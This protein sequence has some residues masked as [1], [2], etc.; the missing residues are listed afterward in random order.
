MTVHVTEIATW[1]EKWSCSPERLEEIKEKIRRGEVFIMSAPKGM[2]DWPQYR[3]DRADALAL[4]LETWK[5]QSDGEN[6][7]EVQDGPR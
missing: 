4:A 3:D 7:H 1:A 6:D 5:E 2:L